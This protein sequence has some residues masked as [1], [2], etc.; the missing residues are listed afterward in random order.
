M[1]R[2]SFITKIFLSHFLVILL[3]SSSIIFITFNLIRS[4][5]INSL[6]EQLK[7]ISLTLNLKI[8]PALLQ[9]KKEELD[10]IIIPLGKD[11]DLRI[12]IINHQ[13][14]VLSDSDYD[15]AQ[16]DNHF[17]RPEI[18]M[19]LQ[20]Q[21]GHSIRY[22]K[23]LKQEMLYY[24][25][26]IKENNKNIGFIR[27]SIYLTE[28][29]ILL[30]QLKNKIV[31]L[32]FL[33]SFIVLLIIFFIFKS[34]LKPMKD[35]IQ[36]SQKISQ[37]DFNI[38][39]RLN[40]QNE[41]KDLADNFNDMS[42]KIK[43][44]FTELAS[45][46]E[47]LNRILFSI[48]EAIVVLDKENKII[49]ANQNFKTLCATDTVEHKYYW[50]VF[51]DFDLTPMIEQIRKEHKPFTQE[52]NFKQ[53]SFLG[54]IAFLDLKQEIVLIFHD[55]TE[56]R[57]VEQMKKE[58]I[59][60]VSHELRTPLTAIKGFVETILH[61]R[62]DNRLEHYLNIINA[63]TDRLIL[64]VQDILTLSKLE[65][66]N[67]ELHSEMLDIPL[68]RNNLIEMFQYKLD[69]KSLSL[70]FHVDPPLE[71]IRGDQYRLEQM[72]INLIDNSIKYTD[73]GSI[74][75][76]LKRENNFL[77]IEI[78]DTGIGIK[79]EHLPRIFERFYVVDK[80]RSRQSGGTGL[81]LSIVKHI[82]FL[83]HGTIEVQSKLGQG[84]KFIIKLPQ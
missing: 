35:L 46:K 36:A 38:H 69:S 67:L 76:T 58:F 7:K 29:N 75:I 65:D 8:Q 53:K 63:H 51:H 21:T 49:L 2:V 27:L 50:E 18:Q 26:L 40:Q 64:I 45:E 37:G 47:E 81:G 15:T 39:L 62:E 52:I 5:Y 14:K 4:H 80:S 48:Q 23:T 42:I 10:K 66:N 9:N 60:N 28:I 12:T 19:A 56:E 11:I 82:V 78:A 71:A 83:H 41:F 43:N 31:F 33:L 16:M 34:F 30:N 70:N 72:F 20:H 3:L 32:S 77:R 17:F 24:A 54:R 61:N 22:S 44:L 84:T 1:K 68:L 6:T 59:A 57:K 13:G 55:I 79:E 25:R 73:Q 74:N